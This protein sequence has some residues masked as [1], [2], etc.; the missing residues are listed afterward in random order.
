MLPACSDKAIRSCKPVCRSLLRLRPHL[1][2]RRPGRRIIA[3]RHN[4]IGL[5]KQRMK[6]ACRCNARVPWQHLAAICP[7]CCAGRSQL[8]ALNFVAAARACS[9]CSVQQLC[10]TTPSG[11]SPPD[12]CNDCVDVEMWL[13]RLLLLGNLRWQMRAEQRQTL[14]LCE[15]GVKYCTNTLQLHAAVQSR[16]SRYQV[17][18]PGERDEEKAQKEHQP[19]KALQRQHKP[20]A[21]IALHRTTLWGRQRCALKV[22]ALKHVMNRLATSGRENIGTPK[23]INVRILHPGSNEAPQWGFQKSS[24]VGSYASVAFWV[25]RTADTAH[26]FQ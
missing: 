11:A 19:R 8:S 16:C 5:D 22:R 24:F 26:L 23:N 6:L 21:D 4:L 17:V 15:E 9:T 7:F 25:P 12:L 14:S 13:D 20:L 18:V 3:G 10:T 2:A 1:L